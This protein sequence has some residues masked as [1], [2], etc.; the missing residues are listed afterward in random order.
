VNEIPP[1]LQ[2]DGLQV[3]FRTAGG[4]LVAVRDLSLRIDPGSIL[5]LVGESGS[6]KTVTALAVMDLLPSHASVE[7]AVLY[8]GRDL[9]AL[10]EAERNALRGRQVAMVFQE[11]TS[12]LNPV[13]RV[14]AQVAEPLRV[15]LGLSRSAARQESLR[16]LTL[17]GLP[18]PASV[19][20]AYP[21][22][23]SG[24]QCQRVL[25]AMALACSPRL[26]LADEPTTALDVTV[27]AGILERLARLRDE[28]GLAILLVSHDL[29][30]VSS[31]ADRVAVMY[32]GSL[33]EQAPVERLFREPAHPYTRGLLACLPDPFRPGSPP[34]PI[35]G[36][37]PD[38]LEPVAGCAFHPRCA[39]AF[40]RCREERPAMEPVP[41]SDE[42]QAACHALQQVRREQRS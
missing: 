3:S 38:P 25:L 5:A 21:H 20:D 19:A 30:V 42:H 4:P 36:Q 2:L 29:A 12:A 33:V 16:L 22:Q 39:Q 1:L 6:G 8:Q 11:P 27:Q 32:A 40:A 28:L 24:G 9:R 34:V 17:A 7:G 15:H 14:A 35:P 31:L 41:G 10:P 26:L 18:D 37:P 23:L 13:L